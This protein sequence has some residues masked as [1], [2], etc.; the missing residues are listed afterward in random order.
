MPACL[1]VN[2]TR[3]LHSISSPNQGRDQRKR[4]NCTAAHDVNFTPAH[5]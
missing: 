4:T 2:F 3:E 1:S 5:T